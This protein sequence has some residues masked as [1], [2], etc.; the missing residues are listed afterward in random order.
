MATDFNPILATLHRMH[1]Q[2]ADL[3]EQVNGGL[4]R[5]RG[6]E[7]RIEELKGIHETAVRTV[8]DFRIS[9]DQKQAQL[10][11]NEVSIIKRKKQLDEAKNEREF[12]GIKEQIAAAEAANAVLSDEI[13][14]GLDYLDTLK[15]NAELAKRNLESTETLLNEIREK[16]QETREWAEAEIRRIKGDFR[17][18]EAELDGEHRMLY[19]KL[20]KIKK[21]DSL[22]SVE[23]K[24]CSGCH[25][26]LPLDVI[27]SIISCQKAVSC[28][29]CSR[30]LYVK[31][32]HHV[33]D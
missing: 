32:G 6:M 27:A 4:R 30:L 20:F 22:T 19:E 18:K 14:E 12:K 21:F 10:E 3:M 11:A 29:M 2:F 5:I 33:K 23:N 17:K 1:R 8:L 13:L 28:P 9:L 31:E 26:I 16:T 7:A 24:C 25:T 15:Q